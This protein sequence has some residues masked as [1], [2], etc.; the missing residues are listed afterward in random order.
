[1]T[2]YQEDPTESNKRMLDL[3]EKT[4][5]VIIDTNK[6]FRHEIIKKFLNFSKK[7]ETESFRTINVVKN[8]NVLAA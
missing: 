7:Q 6:T 4:C 3:I 2:K 8:I 1:M 5:I